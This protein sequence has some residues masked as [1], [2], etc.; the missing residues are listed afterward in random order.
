MVALSPDPYPRTR[1]ASS[2]AELVYITL[3]QDILNNTYRPGQRLSEE[4]IAQELNVSRTPVREAL[5]RLH[6]EGFVE[7]TPHRGAVV[8][9]PSGEELAELCA[10]REV[11]EGLAARLAARSISLIEVYSLERLLA[12]MEAAMAEG[13][14]ADLDALN[15]QF[16][17]TIWI[18]SRNRYLA[19]QLR[20][21]R[22]FVH[23]L[24]ESTLTVQ[25]RKE[26]AYREHKA[27]F[28]A[29]AAGD[30]DEAERLAREHVRKA[31]S[32]RLMVWRKSR[33]A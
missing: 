9:D 22:Q 3:R 24:Q 19:H 15:F 11:L 17:E 12:E 7:I 29:C 26:E 6:A 20:Q 23:R 33:C 4:A 14:L 30:P 31:E 5:K 21:L 32:V 25:G 1:Q 16:H 18:A 2:R 27:L 8:R 28:E 10:V 13:R